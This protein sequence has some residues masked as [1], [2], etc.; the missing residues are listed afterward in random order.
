MTAGA[1]CNRDTVVA[2]PETS[3]HEAAKLMREHHVGCLVVVDD[4]HI[5]NVPVG[6]VTD[7]DM[8]VELLAQGVDPASVTVSDI[9]SVDPVTVDEDESLWD[10]IRK[11]SAR[12]I[13]RL[14][15][16]DKNKALAGLLAVDDVL[17]L[18]S[19]E[20]SQLTNLFILEQKREKQSRM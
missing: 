19:V 18:L 7:R 14:P 16:V 4:R 1:Y 12:G 17:D 13:R 10:A 9:M 2:R 8:V 6:L 20:L 11:M 5:S 15:V 3:I